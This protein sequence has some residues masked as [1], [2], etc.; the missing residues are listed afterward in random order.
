MSQAHDRRRR[1]DHPLGGRSPERGLQAAF[2][3]RGAH[4]GR[5]RAVPNRVGHKP[6][7]LPS[8]SPG[9]FR[10]AEAAPDP[11]AGWPA[12]A[13]RPFRLTRQDW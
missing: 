1:R 3:P 2:G 10:E 7:P 11:G 4:P 13:R 6:K 5:T 9:V 12:E 8:R